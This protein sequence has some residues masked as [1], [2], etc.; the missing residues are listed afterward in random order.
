MTS[1]V[2]TARDPNQNRAAAPA[3]NAAPAMA[4]SRIESIRNRPKWRVTYQTDTASAA[5]KAMTRIARTERGAHAATGPGSRSPTSLDS[6]RGDMNRSISSPRIHPPMA[7]TRIRAMKTGGSR[8]QT[9]PAWTCRSVAPRSSARAAGGH[10]RPADLHVTRPPQG[11]ALDTGSPLTSVRRP[12]RLASVFARATIPWFATLAG[13]PAQR[14]ALLVVNAS[15]Q[16]DLFAA[17][18]SGLSWTRSSAVLGWP[19]V[20]E[21][22]QSAETPRARRP[23]RLPLAPARCDRGTA[24][25]PGPSQ[26]AARCLSLIHISEPTRLGMIS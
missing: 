10:A 24:E 14:S 12:E 15:A 22:W 5:A 19:P 25:D 18:R 6:K 11:G 20:V 4:P 13:G 21:R 2:A 26:L 1:C 8:C 16:A 3:A 23:A 17:G 7:A 9:W